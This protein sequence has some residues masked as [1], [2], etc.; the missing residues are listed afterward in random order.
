M[1]VPLESTLREILGV[2][3][4]QRED[5]LLRQRIIQELQDVVATVPSLR[6]ACFYVAILECLSST[7]PCV[8]AIWL[9]DAEALDHNCMYCA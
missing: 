7:K 5:W 4:P 1:N 8:G 6:G 3:E 9:G 2:I